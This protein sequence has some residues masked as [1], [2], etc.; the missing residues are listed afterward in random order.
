MRSLFLFASCFI[1]GL[2]VSLAI[3][4]GDDS[5]PSAPLRATASADTSEVHTDSVF[6]VTLT[7]ENLT[8][9]AQKIKIPDRGWD[10][11]WKSSN[12]HVTWD[13]WD[14]EEDRDI[15]IEIPPHQT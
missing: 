13:P 8:D 14:C 9:S 12:R 1:A 7:L 10:R 4:H 5:R 6:E 3:C 11:V 15:T 2:A